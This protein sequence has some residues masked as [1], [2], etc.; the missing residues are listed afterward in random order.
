MRYEYAQ[1]LSQDI[2]GEVEAMWANPHQDFPQPATCVCTNQRTTI[3]PSEEYLAAREP[4]ALPIFI[5][6]EQLDALECD[7]RLSHPYA[8]N[9]R[10]QYLD[11]VRDVNI[12]RGRTLDGQARVWELV[13]M[14]FVYWGVGVV[15]RVAV[16]VIA[17]ALDGDGVAVGPAF[18]VATLGPLF[19]LGSPNPCPF[20]IAHPI[21]DLAPLTLEFSLLNYIHS[22]R[23]SDEPP[24]LTA[25]L[26]TQLPLADNIVSPWSDMRYFWESRYSTGNQWIRGGHSLV[27]FF[28]AIT[29][30]AGVWELQ[31]CGRLSG[32]WQYAGRDGGALRNALVRS[33]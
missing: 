5:N 7:H 24:M 31:V 11:V 26:A 18:N 10:I 25:A 23:I 19:Q 9:E 29:S 30:G 16:N 4:P 3:D 13:R 2:L 32:F 17:Q 8:H 28:V 33:G 21:A 20:P 12:L 22:R 27:R 14:P 1:S 15:E 6:P